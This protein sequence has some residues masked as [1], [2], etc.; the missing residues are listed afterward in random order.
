MHIQPHFVGEC[1]HL[2]A[3]TPCTAAHLAR[4]LFH[5]THCVPLDP[6]LQWRPLDLEARVLRCP[7][8]QLTAQPVSTNSL[9]AALPQTE[10]E[11]VKQAAPIARLAYSQCIPEHEVTP[12]LRHPDSEA[13]PPLG[14]RMIL[15]LLFVMG[16]LRRWMGPIALITLLLDLRFAS[17][18]AVAVPVIT[19]RCR[20]Q[21]GRTT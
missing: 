8:R 5:A 1:S 2:N 10:I 9:T 7:A 11:R 3:P 20:A 4:V 19:G 6:L 15:P 13:L 14:I 12:V 16:A 17:R 18:R 21:R